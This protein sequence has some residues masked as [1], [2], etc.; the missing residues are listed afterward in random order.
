MAKCRVVSCSA[1]SFET[2]DIYLQQTN[3]KANEQLEI[4]SGAFRK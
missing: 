1:I 2:T 3:F 4:V